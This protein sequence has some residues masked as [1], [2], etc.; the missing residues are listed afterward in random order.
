MF[1]HRGVD[2]IRIVDVGLLPEN[3]NQGIGTAI[4][5]AILDEASEA[6]K[7]VRLHV[8]HFNRAQRLYERLGFLPIGSSG[9]HVEMESVPDIPAKCRELG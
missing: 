9:V 6:G 4:V 1:V 5:K 7:P 2:E 3:C 8:E